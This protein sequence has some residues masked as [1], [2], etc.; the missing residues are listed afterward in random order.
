MNVAFKSDIQ[1]TQL[2]K[3][4]ICSDRRH[5][6]ARIQHSAHQM[7][8]FR[9]KCDF[10]L[11]PCLNLFHSHLLID[12]F[13]VSI[14]YVMKTESVFLCVCVCTV[15]LTWQSAF[16]IDWNFCVKLSGFTFNRL[17]SSKLIVLF[18]I[19]FSSNKA[20][21]TQKFNQIKN[22]SLFIKR[23]LFDWTGHEL[24]GVN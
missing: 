22:H 12:N 4:S 2:K 16:Q 23:E 24:V 11:V 19:S 7:L 10:S 17:S 6:S 8:S 9:L 21:K 18:I 14:W 1:M 13:N 15:H 20:H 3:K 5:I